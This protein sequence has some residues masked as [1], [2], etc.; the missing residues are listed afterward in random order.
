[1]TALEREAAHLQALADR[2]RTELLALPGVIG[3]SVGPDQSS[4][5]GVAA[6]HAVISLL[7]VGSNHKR[8][9][10]TAARRILGVGVRGQ[11][12]GQ[13]EAGSRQLA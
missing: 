8:A 12:T 10:L 6:A 2:H 13:I 9:A 3:Y 11:I 5:H 7:L 4:A 1:M